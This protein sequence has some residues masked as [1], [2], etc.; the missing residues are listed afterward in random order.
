MLE[1]GDMLY[2]P[3]RWAHDGVAEGECMTCSIGFRAPARGELARELL[4]RAAR[5]RRGGRATSRIYRDA[6]ASRDG[7]RPARMPA[8]L[9]AFAARGGAPPAGRTRR[10]RARARRGADRAQ[11]GR[12]GS[13]AASAVPR[14]GR[15]ALDR[16]TRMLYDARH[17]F[18]NGERIAPRAATRALMRRAGRCAHA[19]A[20]Q[21]RRRRATRRVRCSRN[22]ARRAG[23]S[24]AATTRK[25]DER[26]RHLRRR[27]GCSPRAANATTRSAPALADAARA[28]CRELWLCDA[29]FADW[30]LGE[31]AVIEQPDALGL[32]APPADP[33]RAPASRRCRS[34][35]RAGSNGA[36]AGRTWS[37]AGPSR[38]PSRG[39]CRACCSR[40]ASPPCA[41]STRCTGAAAFRRPRRMPFAAA[42]RLMR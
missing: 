34:A 26:R 40:P 10:A 5:R 1:P 14:A 32:R 2:L 27:T 33:V 23:C 38:R 6:G 28:G 7:R 9:Q 25:D 37:S 12:R 24:R 41:S 39:G 31:R 30:P 20:A 17:V 15:L 21:R 8:A 22:G 18:I 11:A 42:R 36:A 16:R 19:D 35:I 13:S 4:Q 29:D 3:P